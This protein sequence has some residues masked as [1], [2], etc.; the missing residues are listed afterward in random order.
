MSKKTRRRSDSSR[1]RILEDP[2]KDNQLVPLNSEETLGTSSGRHRVNPSDKQL[3]KR[4]VGFGP[5][6]YQLVPSDR[7][8]QKRNVG[9]QFRQT[10]LNPSDRHWQKRNIGLSLD[11]HLQKTLGTSSGRHQLNPSERNIGLNPDRHQVVPSDR[12]WQTNVGNQFRQT[13]IEPIRQTLVE[14]KYWIQSR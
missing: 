8:W 11:R 2:K 14:N 6:R 7:H 5:D 12:H 10:L 3:Q 13:P 4:D 9:N 1:N